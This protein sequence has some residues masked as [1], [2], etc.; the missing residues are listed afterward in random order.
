[1]VQWLRTVR[2]NM[3]TIF[4]VGTVRLISIGRDAWNRAPIVGGTYGD[5]T[6][7]I[8]PDTS[9]ALGRWASHGAPTKA[10]GHLNHL[11]IEM[12]PSIMGNPGQSTMM[13]RTTTAAAASVLT[14]MLGVAAA[15]FSQ[16]P[17]PGPR[18]PADPARGDPMLRTVRKDLIATAATR[19]VARL[20]PFL[21]AEVA[22]DGDPPVPRDRFVEGFRRQPAADRA[23]FWQD[24]RDEVT[25]GFAWLEDA[26]CAPAAV[27]DMPDEANGSFDVVAIIGTGVRVRAAP[28]VNATTIATLTDAVASRGPAPS[29]PAPRGL[30]NGTYE[31]DQIRLHDQRLGWVLSKYVKDRGSRRF[32]FQRINDRWKLVAFGA[33]D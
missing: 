22:V 29:R 13:D 30:A 2:A 9:V 17:P 28:E 32:C 21:A 33:G 24:L 11:H 23:V 25:S 3:D 10:T 7:I 31:W 1:M 19:D 16:D 27:F 5:G 14:M 4:D 15:A 6:A 8:D 18:P 26:V 12:K 20:R